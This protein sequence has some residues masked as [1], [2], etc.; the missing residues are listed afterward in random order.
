ME[1]ELIA[2]DRE[3]ARLENEIEQ[4][5][6]EQ[7]TQPCDDSALDSALD[8]RPILDRDATHDPDVSDA[9]VLATAQLHQDRHELLIEVLRL[10][11][12]LKTSSIA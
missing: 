8:I 11:G 10:R 9:A 4:L 2:A 5:R 6:A 12:K 3:I 7:I 1:M